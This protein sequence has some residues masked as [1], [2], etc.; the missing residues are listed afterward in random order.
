MSDVQEL[1]PDQKREPG[2]GMT[3]VRRWVIPVAAVA[4][5]VMLGV[6]AFG[7]YGYGPLGQL[8]LTESEHDPVAVSFPGEGADANVMLVG[9]A[10]T[11][12]GYCSGQFTA[13]VTE[14]PTEV[15][16]G[17]VLSRE[18]RNGTCAGLGTE[19]NTAWV[20]VVLSAPLGGRRVIRASDGTPLPVREPIGSGP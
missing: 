12:D 8:N 14:T 9:I 3:V 18:Y 15:R 1:E 7:Y 10:W 17:R 13:A 6:V 19:N 4:A 16:V 11:K 5:V 20:D 2:R